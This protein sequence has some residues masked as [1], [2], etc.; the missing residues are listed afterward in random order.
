MKKIKENKK[1][2]LKSE[3]I[4]PEKKKSIEKNL[5]DGLTRS[6]RYGK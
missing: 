4:M 6:Q 2:L 5:S 3:N 1:D